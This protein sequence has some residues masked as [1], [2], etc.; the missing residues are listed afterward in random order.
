M[1]ELV[2]QFTDPGDE[3]FDWTMGGGTTAIGAL[4]AAGGPRLF[5]GC[6]VRPAMF[7]LAAARIDAELSGSTRS[8]VVRGQK[9]LFE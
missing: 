8:A 3:I 6:E 1:V 9:G 5:V 2:E 4:R 7:E